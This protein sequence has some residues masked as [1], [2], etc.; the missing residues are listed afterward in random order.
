MQRRRN[1]VRCCKCAPF[2]LRREQMCHFERQETGAGGSCFVTATGIRAQSRPSSCPIVQGD[3][4]PGLKRQRGL[5]VCSGL[6]DLQVLCGTGV[7][8]LSKKY[9]TGGC[10]IIHGPAMFW[11]ASK[12]PRCRTLPP[13]SPPFHTP[14][15][16][17][18]TYV[19]TC[20]SWCRPIFLYYSFTTS[21]RNFRWSSSESA[22]AMMRSHPSNCIVTSGEKKSYVG[23]IDYLCIVWKIKLACIVKIYLTSSVCKVRILA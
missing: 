17:Q 16:P 23:T 5:R 15:K 9:G 21:M 8:V 19:L 13:R 3:A 7:S 4:A 11:P 12:L 20:V 18:M 1:T 2:P 22:T 14:R 10:A 6:L